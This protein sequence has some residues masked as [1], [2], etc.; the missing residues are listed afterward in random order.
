MS[1]ANSAS[2][3][4]PHVNTICDLTREEATSK[5]ECDSCDY[6]GPNLWLCLHYDCGQYVGCGE[7]QADH[8]TQH[9]NEK[10]HPITLN[11]TTFRVWCYVCETEV[12]L[13]DYFPQSNDNQ[14]YDSHDQDQSFY[15]HPVQPVPRHRK[16]STGSYRPILTNQIYVAEE[17]SGSGSDSD[18]PRK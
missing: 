18:T 2:L 8:S 13:E 14:S 9:F 1:T 16:I 3:P 6:P 4:C 17:T 7:N 12:F 5:Y 11:L 10:G 15:R